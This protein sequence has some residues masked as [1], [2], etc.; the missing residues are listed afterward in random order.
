MKLFGK[1]SILLFLGK[2][3]LNCEIMLEQKGQHIKKLSPRE[4]SDFGQGH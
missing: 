2:F 3:L 1:T 4:L